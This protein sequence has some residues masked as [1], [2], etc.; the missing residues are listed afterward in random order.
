MVQLNALVALVS[1][2]QMLPHLILAIS[3]LVHPNRL[4]SFILLMHFFH[5]FCLFCGTQLV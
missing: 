4:A 1:H 5:A 3:M 2:V